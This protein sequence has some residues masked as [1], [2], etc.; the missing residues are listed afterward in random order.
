MPKKKEKEEKGKFIEVGVPGDIAVVDK[1]VKK[2]L[3]RG[4]VR[5][6][7]E[8]ETKERERE[9]QDKDSVTVLDSNGNPYT[10]YLQ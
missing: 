5:E 7:I 1:G 8:C 9:L 3:Y 4:E 10:I 6:I 2:V